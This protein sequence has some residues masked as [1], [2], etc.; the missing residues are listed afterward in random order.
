MRFLLGALFAATAMM[1]VTI[2]AS[3]VSATMSGLDSSRAVYMQEIG[4]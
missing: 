2:F 4:Q 1:G 3:A